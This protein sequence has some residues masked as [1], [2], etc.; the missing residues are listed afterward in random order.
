M[1]SLGIDLAVAPPDTAACEITWLANRAHGRLYT[2]RL[3]DHQLLRLID[4]ADKV[5]IDC[6]F[7]LPQPFINAVTAHAN[8]ASWPGRGQ[9][10]P[11]HRGPCATASPTRLCTSR[12]ASGR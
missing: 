12:S 7:G 2:D 3:D 4:T 10:G 1:H 6:P 5:G 8:A 9:L 11:D